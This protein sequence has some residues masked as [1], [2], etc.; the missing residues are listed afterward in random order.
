[1]IFDKT[2]DLD[3]IKNIKIKQDAGDVIFKETSNDS[4]QV[5]LYGEDGDD[6]DR[7]IDDYN[8]YTQGGWLKKLY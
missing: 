6:I 5:V 8:H 1:M 2:F 3:N 4:I 7:F